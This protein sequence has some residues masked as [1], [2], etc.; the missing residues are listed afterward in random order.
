MSKFVEFGQGI[1]TSDFLR[2]FFESRR[3]SSN[4]SDVRIEQS[5]TMRFGE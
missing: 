4:C 5:G 1:R 2:S 3:R